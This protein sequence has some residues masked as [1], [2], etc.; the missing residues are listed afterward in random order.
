M[1]IL[2]TLEAASDWTIVDQSNTS[3]AL[4]GPELNL[5]YYLEDEKEDVVD[6]YNLHVGSVGPLSRVRHGGHIRS[7]SSGCELK[8]HS[9]LFNHFE[10]LNGSRDDPQLRAR[11]YVFGHF[12][13]YQQTNSTT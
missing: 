8:R 4:S 6:E 12:A 5:G 2:L 3:E 7:L 11:R 13:K 9:S 1:E 10:R